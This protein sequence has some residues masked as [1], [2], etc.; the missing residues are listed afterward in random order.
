MHDYFAFIGQNVQIARHS[1]GMTQEHL[2]RELDI[3]T[4]VISRLET[5][6]TMVSVVRLM[7]IAQV[8][9]V[10]VGDLLREP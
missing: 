1:A 7:E 4:S 2:A 9:D 8:L 6:R 10:F 3:S 5:G